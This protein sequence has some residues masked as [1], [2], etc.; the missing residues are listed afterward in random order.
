MPHWTQ[1]KHD[2][3]KVCTSLRYE[4]NWPVTCCKPV[5]FIRD[6]V[7]YCGIHDPEHQLAMQIKREAKAA[8]S[9]ATP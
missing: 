3:S 5:K 1:E 8:A 9:V 2:K 7:G 6:G 4:G